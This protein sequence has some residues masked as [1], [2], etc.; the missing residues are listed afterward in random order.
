MP[1]ER[2]GRADREGATGSEEKGDLERGRA[3]HARA[4]WEESFLRLSGA[5]RRASLDRDDLERLALAAA[6]T[7]RDQELLHVLE[8]LYQVHLDAGERARAARQAFWLA[9]RLLSLGE[10]ARASGWLGRGQRALEAVDG[11]CAERGYL[12][13]PG[14]ARHL[15]TGQYAEAARV[16]AEAAEIG[17][18][19][20]DADL[21]SL[22]RSM[23]GRAL[24]RDAR[25][26]PGLSLLD[27]TMVAVT[28]GE[29]S[30]LVTGLVYCSVIVACQHVYALDRAREWTAALAAWCGRQPQ[31]VTFAGACL[32]HRA[33]VL[34]LGGEWP[35]AID[36]ACRARERLPPADTEAR[37]DAHYQ[38]AE[39]HRLRGERA[40]AEDAYQLASRLGREPQPGLALLRLAEGRRTE[41]ATSIRRVLETTRAPWQR[42]RY[43]PAS[44]EILLSSGDVEEARAAA[45][46]LEEI[47]E[48]YGTEVLGAMAAHARGAVRL[49]EGDAR[50]AVEPLRHAF[51]VWQKVGAPY[52][53][54][55]IRLLLGRAYHDLGDREGAA[56][57]RSAARAVFSGLGAAP[58]LAALDDA[59]G[60][61]PRGSHGLSPRERQVLRLV[62][63][64]RTNKAIALELGLSERTIDRHL[65][66]IF[67]KI[68]V[69]S[70]AAATAFAYEHGLVHP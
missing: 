27:E 65:S 59:G 8:R 4:E 9:F 10:G 47:A 51:S 32:V 39:I 13:L 44:V 15:A 42:A 24:V 46:E 49:A 1:D 28:S 52:I 25:V 56:L 70:R 21:V 19:H 53:A 64:G 55:R 61:T 6:L 23:E 62:A 5:D 3:A 63:G 22:A 40:A 30:P 2:D 35:Q 38:Q 48:R 45:R 33:E 58:D 26:E 16:A 43:L 68:H 7:G 11:D 18:R 29:L 14:V 60:R 20:D 34:L 36:E 57:E 12:L 67:T 31:L 17:A 41:A 66:N 69:S 37:A 54:A 50:A